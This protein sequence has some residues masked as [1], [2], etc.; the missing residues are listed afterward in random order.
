VS[1]RLIGEA[2]DDVEYCAAVCVACRRVWLACYESEFDGDYKCV[3]GMRMRN[4]A[5]IYV[6][7]RIGAERWRALFEGSKR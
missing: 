3:C 5:A 4:V 6:S 7:P 1:P 2:R